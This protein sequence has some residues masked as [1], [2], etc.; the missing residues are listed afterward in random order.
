MKELIDLLLKNVLLSAVFA[1]GN[2][3]P[4]LNSDLKKTALSDHF[5]MV[6]N[7][8]INENIIFDK[9]TFVNGEH[10]VMISAESTS[11]YLITLYEFLEKEDSFDRY[12]KK[13]RC[14]LSYKGYEG[15]CIIRMKGS[16]IHVFIIPDGA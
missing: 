11:Q 16:K 7:L 15:K 10:G 4:L 3:T 6:H 13:A 14:E 2:L 1:I 8:A 9:A 12:N 5:I